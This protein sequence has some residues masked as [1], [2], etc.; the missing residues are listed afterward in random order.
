[1]KDKPSL[2]K[3]YSLAMEHHSHSKSLRTFFSLIAQ[4]DQVIKKVC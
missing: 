1:M 3:R 2:F 4:N